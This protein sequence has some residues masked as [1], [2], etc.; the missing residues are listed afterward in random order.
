MKLNTRTNEASQQASCMKCALHRMFWRKYLNG[1]AIVIFAGRQGAFEQAVD[2]AHGAQVL[3]EAG[4]L[5]Q[6][7]DE[8][9]LQGPHLQVQGYVEWLQC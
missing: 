3:A 1:S 2:L 8:G 5:Q 6:A 9:T 4:L 7:H